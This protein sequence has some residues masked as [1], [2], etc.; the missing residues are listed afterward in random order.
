LTA[1]P[2]IEVRTGLSPAASS[3]HR[4]EVPEVFSEWSWPDR[5][6]ELRVRWGIGRNDY[7]VRP[8]LY[9]L[10]S[11]DRKSPVL[12]S[13]NYKLS[14]DVLRRAMSGR[15]A[16]ILVLDSDGVNVWCAAGKGTFATEELVHRIERT[17][18][19]EV[20]DHR[21]LI[22][23]QL[24]AVG[25]AAHLVRKHSGFKVRFGP[26][27]ADDLPAFIDGGLKAD[28]AMRRVT[29]TFGERLVLVPMEL[30]PALRYAVPLLVLLLLLGGLGR[31]GYSLAAILSNGMAS[32]TAIAGTLVAGAVA[33]PLLLPWLPGRSFSVKGLLPGTAWA[34]LFA[35]PFSAFLAADVSVLVRAAWIL[36]IPALSSFLAMNF[37]GSSTVTSL[38]GVK[39]EMHYAF[40]LQAAAA[41]GGLL[42]WTAGLFTAGGGA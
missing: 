32:V 36:A 4:S 31:G 40:P 22:L 12:V 14:F 9:A 8:G 41:V 39:K 29:F 30:V 23:P 20:V 13:A 16:W 10:G 28:P 2:V 6:G 3:L 18:L 33:T 24:G 1:L 7:R 11:P 21:R 26:V 27:R 15:Q 37:T 38:S 42:L 17:G 34:L 19:A 5:L 25:V 35:L